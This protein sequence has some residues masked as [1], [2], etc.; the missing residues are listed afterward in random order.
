MRFLTPHGA[1][2]AGLTLSL[3]LLPG[4]PARAQD[5]AWS[6]LPSAPSPRWSASG[7]VLD[8]RLYLV[9][10]G[11]SGC[12]ATPVVQAFDPATLTW[13]THAS[14]PFARLLHDSDVLDGILYLTGGNT[15]CSTPDLASTYAYDP[16]ADLWSSRAPM[17]TAR[18]QLRMAALDGLLYATGGISGGSTIH[19]AVEVY[20]PSAD[21]WFAVSPMPQPRYGHALLAHDGLLYAMGGT[22]NSGPL[23]SVVVYDPAT[24]A[25]TSRSPMPFPATWTHAA[26]T[27]GFLYVIGG[28]DPGVPTGRVQVYDPATDS[29]S[30]ATSM[31]TPRGYATVET[32]G[33]VIYVANGLDDR[34]GYGGFTTLEAFTPFPPN[35]TPI[36]AA[37]AD[38]FAAE[39]DV[40]S[41]DG[42]G[43][44][45]PDGEPLTYAWSQVA[46]PP[47]ALAGADTAAP[48]FVAPAVALGGATLTFQLIVSDGAAASASDTVDVQIRNVNNPPIAD[49]GLDQAVAE[50]A[51]VVLDGTQSADVDGDV[52]AFH[53]MQLS[54]PA[55]P[56]IDED[57][58]LASFVSP[59]VGPLGASLTFALTVFDG[60]DAVT[61]FVD[62]RVENVNH[63][64]IAHAGADQTH[65]EGSLVTLDGSSSADPDLDAIQYAWQQV[66]GPAVALDFADTAAPQ[67]VAP[68]VGA[69]GASLT[70]EL[71]VHDGVD[72]SAADTVIVHVLDANAPPLCDA[73]APSVALLWPPDHKM[74][75]ISIQGVS[76]PD[77]LNVQIAVTHVTPDEATSGLGSGDTGPDAVILGSTVLLRAERD[78]SGD[79][80]VYVIHFSADDGQGGV[81]HGSVRVVVPAN[82]GRNGTA[83]DSGQNHSSL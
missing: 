57:Q 29:W 43:S 51:W 83:T 17:P 80:R 71:I 26:A 73:A 16:H 24:D 60:T 47:V 1:S 63:L 14:L 25:W 61:D 72:A 33:N 6:T 20:D 12:G 66:G 27:Q 77:S 28:N 22:D 74:I 64:P 78:G 56:I 53:W 81:C 62:V 21:A 67:F 23:Q 11:N 30:L 4:L 69:G 42:S 39:F 7:G 59:G 37:G 44:A 10:G 9:S 3:L 82:R 50:V 32:I 49:A 38:A 54:G 45:D 31:P 70:F 13:S 18:R 48:S 76:D 65:A 36:A 15:G 5:G 55:V 35:R 79:G 58:A 68:Q 34:L 2:C 46:G 52:L 8:G 40:V 75:P 41:L 19:S